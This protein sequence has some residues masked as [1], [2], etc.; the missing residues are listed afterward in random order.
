MLLKV[1]DSLTGELKYSVDLE[2]R[3]QAR[4]KIIAI[5]E[6]DQKRESVVAEIAGDILV[7]NLLNQLEL[8]RDQLLSRMNTGDVDELNAMSSGKITLFTNSIDLL[9]KIKIEKSRLGQERHEL[10][11]E[12]QVIAPSFIK[13]AWPVS[14]NKHAV[15]RLKSKIKMLRRTQAADEVTYQKQYQTSVRLAKEALEQFISGLQTLDEDSILYAPSVQSRNDSQ[16][17]ISHVWANHIDLESI[18]LTDVVVYTD[19][20]RKTSGVTDEN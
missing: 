14:D 4:R 3:L 2:L 11:A 20:L 16:E 19:I 1:G 13:K 5:L 10:E 6:A 9:R 12:L 15:E 17:A 7:E 18:G 8:F